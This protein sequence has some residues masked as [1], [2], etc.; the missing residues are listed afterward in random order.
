MLSVLLT[1]YF[2]KIGPELTSVANIP[3]FFSPQSQSTQL[4]ILVVSPSGS[5]MW[6]A[7]TAWLDEWYVGLCPGS[8]PV[9]PRPLKQRM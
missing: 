8:E 7:A 2:R 6:D 1:T 9:N 4:Y 5:S 3:L